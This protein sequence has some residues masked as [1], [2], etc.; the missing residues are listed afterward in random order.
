VNVPV[1]LA[2][3]LAMLAA[4]ALFGWLGARPPDLARGPRLVPY[5]FL[6]VLACAAALTLIVHL[7]NL[8]GVVT[9]R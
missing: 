9:G 2:L 8:A 6:M 1:T 5:R 7:V 3:T 4:A